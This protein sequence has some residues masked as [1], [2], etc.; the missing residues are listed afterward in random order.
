MR[1][2]LTALGTTG[3]MAGLMLGAPAQ[4]QAV[5]AAAWE[6]PTKSVCFY[7][8]AGG[9]G[10]RCAWPGAQNDPDWRSGD[11]KCSWAG[12]RPVGSLRVMPN[13]AG[14]VSH[15]PDANYGGGRTCLTSGAAGLQ[16]SFK[17]MPRVLS[18]KTS[19]S[20]CSV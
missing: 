18:H 12:S 2:I 10:Q 4:A 6:C 16:V 9:T 19:S 13:A 8:G 15:Y 5:E 7:T 20:G 14:S 1:K 3:L 11:L 17:S